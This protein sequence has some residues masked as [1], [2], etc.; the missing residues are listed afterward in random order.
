MIVRGLLSGL[1]RRLVRLLLGLGLRVRKLLDLGRQRCGSRRRHR[2]RADGL[3]SGWW[4]SYRRRD[5]RLVG[6]RVHPG[7]YSSPYGDSKRDEGPNRECAEDPVSPL[8]VI[9]LSVFSY[10]AYCW[11]SQFY[12]TYHYAY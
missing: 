3:R 4:S 12:L 1:L 5:V 9:L 10:V 8:P 7:G 6:P 11:I 2:T